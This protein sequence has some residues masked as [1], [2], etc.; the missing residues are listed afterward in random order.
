MKVYLKE[1]VLKFPIRNLSRP[2][3]AT[4]K[5]E[6]EEG[7]GF[8]SLEKKEKDVDIEKCFKLS[9][10]VKTKKRYRSLISF[11]SGE[12]SSWKIFRKIKRRDLKV[13]PAAPGKSRLVRLEKQL[14]R[15]TLYGTEEK[16][17]VKQN[18]CNNIMLCVP[19]VPG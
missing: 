16:E 2:P 19:V 11:L 10:G 18:T 6:R 3:K 1:L 15:A 8:G 4:A 9:K 5:R 12:I 14:A 7:G 13:R 17:K